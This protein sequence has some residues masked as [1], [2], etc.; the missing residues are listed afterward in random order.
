VG[1]QPSTRSAAD[2]RNADD[3]FPNDRAITGQD[4]PRSLPPRRLACIDRSFKNPVEST[5]A[6]PGRLPGFPTPA[7]V[8]PN[9]FHG[10]DRNSSGA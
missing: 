5:R 1:C 6:A 10:P 2:S 8:P 7:P 4:Q 3:P 9:I